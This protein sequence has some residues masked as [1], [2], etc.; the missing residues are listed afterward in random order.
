MTEI[1]SSSFDR[2]VSCPGSITVTALVDPRE[3]DEGHEGSY[4]HWA[5]ADRLVRELGAIPPEGGLPAPDVP[6]GYK[7]PA[8]SLWMVDWLSR[9]VQET[10]PANWSLMVEVEMSHQF[11]RWR[12]TGHADVIAISPDGTECIQID[13]KTGRDPVDPADNNWQVANYLGLAKLEWPS[14]RRG[15][16]QIAQPRVSEEDGIERVSTVVVEDLDLL[17]ATLDDEIC[18]ALDQPMRLKTSKKACNWCVGC[19]C[20][21]IRAQQKIMELTLTPDMLAQI[22]RTPDDATLGE[23]V[24]IG[25]ILSR[26]LDDAEKMLHERLDAQPEVVASGGTRITRVVQKGSY[27]WPDPLAALTAVKELL[28]SDASQ[29]KVLT[30][31]VTRLKDEIATVFSVPKSGKAATTAETIFDARLRPLVEQSDRKI[32]KFL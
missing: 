5:V 7:L 1:R 32:L 4:I 8:N 26:P 9:H 15:K 31:S 24:A 27:S 28:P 25:R 18:K 10:V 30:P 16:G 3:G 23:F 17:V 12:N 11:P 14:L 29:A 22:K 13:Y 2:V 21:A 6:A 20:P 19:S